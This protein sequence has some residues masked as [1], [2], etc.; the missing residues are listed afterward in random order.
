[1]RQE[2]PFCRFRSQREAIAIRWPNRNDV[3]RICLGRCVVIQKMVH[4]AKARTMND[5]RYCLWMVQHMSKRQ[6]H[7][8]ADGNA[9][10][11][12]TLLNQAKSGH[13]APVSTARISFVRTQVLIEHQAGVETKTYSRKPHPAVL[14]HSAFVMVEVVFKS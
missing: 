3:Q 5:G 1:M 4:R 10:E 11:F 6:F 12:T 2:E 9:D 8:V 14:P 7:D 13:I